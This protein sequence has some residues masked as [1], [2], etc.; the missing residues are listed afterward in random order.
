MAHKGL[1]LSK[2]RLRKVG[3]CLNR[4][5]GCHLFFKK[6]QAVRQTIS[7]LQCPYLGDEADVLHQSKT[8]GLFGNMDPQ[9]RMLTLPG[10]HGHSLGFSTHLRLT[11]P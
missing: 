9:K 11:I 7:E 4:G 10:H 2:P 5:C 8:W 3:E 6:N 1:S